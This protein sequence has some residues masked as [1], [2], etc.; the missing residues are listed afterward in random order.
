MQDGGQ[1]GGLVTRPRTRRALRETVETLIVAIVLAL[2]ARTFVIEPFLVEGTSMLNSLHNHERLLVNKVWW[3]GGSLHYGE[4]IVFVPPI[5]GVTEDY[6]KRVIATGGQTVS[7]RSG[8]VYVNGKKMPQPFLVHG[9]VSTMDNWTMAPEKV[10]AGDLFVLGDNRANSEDSRFFGFVKL[11]EVQG[12]VF[13]AFW[14][15]SSFGSV[16]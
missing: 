14:P 5:S 13:W 10:P 2:V 3:L 6:V 11:S 9:G 12:V 1:H 16:H 7:M 4:I 8:Q 15:M